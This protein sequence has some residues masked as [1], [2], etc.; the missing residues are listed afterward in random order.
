[1]FLTLFSLLGHWKTFLLSKVLS[2]YLHLPILVGDHRSLDE[3]SSGEI[4]FST[5]YIQ[6]ETKDIQSC[7]NFLVRPYYND[8]MVFQLTPTQPIPIRILRI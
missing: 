6:N 4:T 8:K 5:K 7:E 3:D 2:L 1:M